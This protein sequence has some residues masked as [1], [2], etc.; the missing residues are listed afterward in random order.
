MSNR[1]YL[2]KPILLCIESNNG[3]L[4]R[5]FTIVKKIDEGASAVCYEAFHENSGR[6]VL[7]EFYPQNAYGV[8]REGNGQLTHSP[9]Y[10]E[11]RERFLAEEKQYIEPYNMLLAAKRDSAGQDLSSFIPEFEIY[12][13]CDEDGKAVGTTYI[14]TPEPKLETFDVICEEI[15]NHPEN[16][17]EYKLVTVLNAIDSLT[18]CISALHSAELVHRDIKPSNF[19]F[20]KRGDETLTQTLTM[21]DVNSI[22]SVYRRD[23]EVVGSEGFMEPEAGYEPVDN[24]TDIYAIGA[25]LFYA[26]VV[27]EETKAG[28]Y[29][30]QREYY[31]R[32]RELVDNSLLIQASEANSHPKLRNILT[33]ILQK[34]LCERADRYERCED[35][36]RD[37]AAA[38]YYVLPPDAAGK[39]RDGEKWILADVEKSLDAHQKKNSFL[40]IQYHLYEH[41]LY[42]YVKKE[43]DEINV[44]VLG[45]GSY[46]Q[47]F[48][49]ACL[50][51]G[52][53]QD[54][55]LKVTVVSD[56]K[57]DRDIYL[58]ERPELANF[59]NIDGSLEQDCDAYGDI[60]FETRQ[61]KYDDPASNEK[62]GR[63]NFVKTLWRQ[64][65]P[66]RFHCPGE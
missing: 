16:Q 42:Q 15:H 61:L 27:T 45:F 3:T 58:S 14:W 19:G 40:A 33:G 34:C 2:E 24:K 11:A 21:F 63:G 49:D 41:P 50:Q 35:L 62:N 48:L 1:Q 5:T 46:G 18:K 60:S 20:R 53:V 23:V 66:L 64:K 59:F 10:P 32:L 12:R 9:E 8:G 28:D 22:C 47:K 44:L 54:K 39:V 6:G 13:G 51:N 38:L 7:K 57:A 55:K 56:D 43:E 37:L 4:K 30:Y 26:L 25:T 36:H 17:P 29:R 31:G 52:Q 65:P